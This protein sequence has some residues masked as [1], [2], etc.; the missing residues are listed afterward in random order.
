MGLICPVNWSSYFSLSSGDGKPTDHCGFD[1][2]VRTE[3]SAWRNE[4]VGFSPCCGLPSTLKNALWS[5]GETIPVFIHPEDA[6][7]TW[8]SETQT[9]GSMLSHP[10]L[11]EFTPLS[12]CML[13]DQWP[14]R[15]Q[16]TVALN[17]CMWFPNWYRNFEDCQIA[18]VGHVYS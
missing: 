3:T 12:N 5:C 9:Q 16:E 1:K 15:G 17:S 11:A 6:D 14:S 10:M 8:F 7:K 13:G 4:K 2:M 18:V